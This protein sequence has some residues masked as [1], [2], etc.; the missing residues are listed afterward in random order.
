M[1]KT[2]VVIR[3]QTGT[4]LSRISFRLSLSGTVRRYCNMKQG[5]LGTVNCV[6]I[7]HFANHFRSLVLHASLD[8]IDWAHG[9]GV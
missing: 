5:F 4:R 9:R 1:E 8:P 2:N 6:P 3:R 7:H